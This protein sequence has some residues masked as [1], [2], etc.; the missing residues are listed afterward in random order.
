MY[1]LHF[2]R[3]P[4]RSWNSGLRAIELAEL[5]GATKVILLGYDCQIDYG[6]HWHEDHKGISN[7]TDKVCRDWRIQFAALAKRT[8][9]E[10][11]NCSRRTALTCF[12]RAELED[13]LC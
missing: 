2:Y 8:K 6:V 10:I 4:T 13:V 5:L 7:P 12:A 3:S 11:I 9:I 1:K